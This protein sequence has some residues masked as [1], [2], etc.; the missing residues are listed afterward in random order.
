L[1]TPA[2]LIVHIAL[3]AKASMLVKELL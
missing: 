1:R 3:Q 2:T